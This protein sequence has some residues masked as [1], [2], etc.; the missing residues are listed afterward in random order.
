MDINGLTIKSSSTLSQFKNGLFTVPANRSAI[1]IDASTVDTN[2]AAQYNNIG[3]ATSSAGT[4]T[5]VT[6]TG[7]P[8]SFIWFTAGFGGLYGEAYNAG[9]GNPG[10]IRF[11]DSAIKL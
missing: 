6:L 4:S 10:S 3:F 9:D 8:A 2:P 7:A 5:N 1:T 11:D